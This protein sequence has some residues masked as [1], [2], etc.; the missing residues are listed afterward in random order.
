LERLGKY[1]II[2]RIGKGAMGEVWEAQDT[3][4]NRHVALKT[5]SA[6]LSS[7]ETLRKRFQREAQSAARLNHPN[8]ITVYEFGDQG[9]TLFMAM[10]LL[11]GRDLK[12]AIVQGALASLP[13]Q[14]DVMMQICEGLAFAHS[15]EIVHRDLKP[16]NIHIL[17]DGKVKIMDFGLARLSGSDMTRTGLVMGTPNYM[18]PEQV[19][20]EKADARSDIFAA[21]CIFY[22]VLT[23]HKAFEADS[24]HAVLYKVMQEEPAPARQVVPQV[25][26]VLF[27]VLDR[28]LSKSP[29]ERFQDAGQL[30][31]AL[32]RAR[33][34]IAAG[35]GNSILPE[36]SHPAAREA[37]P[38]RSHYGSQ[39][40][41]RPNIPP[42]P[43][44]RSK[45]PLIVAALV[46][47]AG[48]VG[49]GGWAILRS[50][51]PADTGSQAGSEGQVQNLAKAL[52][53]TQV[54]L[55]RRKLE[56][57]DWADA[58]RQAEK[59]LKFDPDNAEARKLIEKAGKSQTEVEAAA[60]SVRSGPTASRT[61]AL[62][63]LLQL[64]PEHPLVAQVTPALEA[65]F[66]DR[67][68]EARRL[69]T[70]ARGRAQASGGSNRPDFG[71]AAAASRE[72]EKA[73]QAG[74]FVAAAQTFLKARDGFE[75]ARAA[76]QP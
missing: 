38:A 48:V 65:G 19:R 59:A 26:A 13:Q 6:E 1:R 23:R 27:Q 42:P 70:E 76:V 36:L 54:E 52:A 22:E 14:L 67:A 21:G 58:V 75:R 61:A 45:I 60:A 20:G 31:D 53:D 74:R 11:E 51:P 55:A 62:W 73:F 10:E 41:S 3:V 18:S 50:R 44:S 15:H 4:L 34:A 35:R 30:K 64:A 49:L 28:A 56:A 33:E 32:Q 5:I 46:A 47:A 24:M 57:R 2:G 16:A 72:A 7:D 37:R 69:M 8:I 17:P 9:G 25:P 39:V 29:T 43:P 66:K 71:Q 68:E 40:G 63:T 12:Q